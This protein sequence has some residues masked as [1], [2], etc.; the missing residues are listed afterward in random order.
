MKKLLLGVAAFGLLS[1]AF[2]PA[3]DICVLRGYLR[4]R[5]MLVRYASHHIQ[6]MQKALSEMN[7]KLQHVVEDITGMTGMRIMRAIVE[8]ER[9]PQALAELRDYRCKRDAAT[10]AL[11][12]EGNWREEHLFALQQALELYDDYQRKIAACDERIEAVLGSCE[13]RT[14]GQ[15]PPP[16]RKG[17]KAKQGNAPRFDVRTSLYRMTGVDLTQLDGFDEH[18]AL[19]ALSETGRDMTPWPTVKHFS[20]WLRL[21]PGKK[22]SG[23]K[24]LS[25]RTAPGASRAAEIFRLAANSL[26]RSDSALGAYLRRKK[27]QLGAPKAI[28]ATAHKIARIYYTLLRYGHE[29]VDPGQEA[30]ER[31]YRERVVKNLRRRARQLGYHLVEADSTAPQPLPA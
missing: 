8:G 5:G 2:R 25:S 28:T 17:K 12:L 22:I 1:G 19:K 21:C 20:A 15:A 10:I 7:V 9:D 23:G 14:Q 30:Y 24:V 3:N 27:A 13:D 31:Q 29:Y 26:H 11:A 6:H 16:R 4:Q 18:L